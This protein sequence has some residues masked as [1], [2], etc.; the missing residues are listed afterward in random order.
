LLGFGRPFSLGI[1]VTRNVTK[2]YMKNYINSEAADHVKRVYSAFNPIRIAHI[3]YKV[4]VDLA[5][6]FS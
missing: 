1:N 2:L 5:R 6:G 4:L 3:K